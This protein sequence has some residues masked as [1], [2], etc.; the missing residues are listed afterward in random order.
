[1]TDKTPAQL[2]DDAAEAIRALNHRTLA[3]NRGDEDWAYPG[4]AYSVAGNLSQAAMMLPQALEQ[5]TGLVR[6]LHE[7]G[8]LRS[9]R[10][11]L[12]A[13]LAETLSGLSEARI[14]AETLYSALN[15]AHSGLSPIA[16][17]G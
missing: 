8:H 4:D 12:E 6:D 13:D 1:M 2:A 15:R 11:Q 10:D 3:W 14:A 7:K 9:D 16:Y 17:K 5:I